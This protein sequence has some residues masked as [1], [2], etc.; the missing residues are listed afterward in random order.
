MFIYHPRHFLC[1]SSCPYPTSFLKESGLSCFRGSDVCSG[2]NSVWMTNR[3]ALFARYIQCSSST[4]MVTMSSMNP[5]ID[6]SVDAMYTSKGS[7]VVRC[8]ADFCFSI[9]GSKDQCGDFRSSVSQYSSRS[10]LLPR[11]ISASLTVVYYAGA[12][13]VP[14]GN[15]MQRKASSST[16]AMDVDAVVA[17][18]CIW[19]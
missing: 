2:Q 17:F 7:D 19:R 3:A 15:F 6:A 12:G 18:A 10:R 14:T 9:C 1:L 16:I 11:S 8:L 13:V 4:V 5:S